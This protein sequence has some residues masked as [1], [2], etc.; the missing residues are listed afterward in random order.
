MP[1]TFIPDESAAERA[2]RYAGTVAASAISHAM[3]AED[4]GAEIAGPL[5]DHLAPVAADG[6]QAGIAKVREEMAVQPALPAPPPGAAGVIPSPVGAGPEE[7]RIAISLDQ[8]HRRAAEWAQRHAGELVEQISEN[9]RGM[10]RSAVVDA[11]LEGVNGSAELAERLMESA[12]FSKTRATRI[13]TTEI[14]NSN[15]AGSLEAY[16]LAGAWGKQWLPAIDA[17]PVCL[18]NA[19]EGPIALD[20]DFIGGV[21][22]PTQHP[23][24]RCSLTVVFY[25]PAGHNAPPALH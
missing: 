22:A 19:A 4:W 10:I 13:A 11:Q 17:C 9:T 12:A 3:A 21:S 2:K 1:A 16:R 25:A 20:K 6:I 5:A 7:G 24:C 15:N 8:V 14:L 18:A 23:N